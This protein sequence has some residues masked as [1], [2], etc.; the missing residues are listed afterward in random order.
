MGPDGRAAG[1]RLTSM[2]LFQWMH[3]TPDGIFWQSQHLPFK[4]YINKCVVKEFLQKIVNIL[5]TDPP[6]F[7]L[8]KRV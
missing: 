7:P 1:G 5:P 6:G 2:A 4:L 3:P 8:E